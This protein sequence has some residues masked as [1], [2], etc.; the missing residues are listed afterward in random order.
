MGGSSRHK[1]EGS[2]SRIEI[3]QKY[4]N[5][6]KNNLEYLKKKNECTGRKDKVIYPNDKTQK[7]LIEDYVKNKKKF[8]DALEMAKNR[9]GKQWFD[10][11]ENEE[12]KVI[13][14]YKRF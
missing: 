2:S 1:G 13:G 11:F 7:D 14:E 4:N 12:Y 8:G 10:R 3:T 9:N 5:K 6:I